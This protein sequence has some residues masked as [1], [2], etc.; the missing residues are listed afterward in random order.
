MLDSTAIQLAQKG[1]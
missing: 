1:M